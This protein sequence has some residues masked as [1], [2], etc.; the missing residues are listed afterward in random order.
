MQNKSEKQ[1]YLE[2]LE[3]VRIGEE[4]IAQGKFTDSKTLRKRMLE[5]LFPNNSQPQLEQRTDF[6]E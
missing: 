6:E 4:Q 3:A 1:E 5:R 2:I